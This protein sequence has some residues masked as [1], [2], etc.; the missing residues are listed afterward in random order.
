MKT[1]EIRFDVQEDIL[2]ALNQNI[3]EFTMQLRLYTA[4]QLFK[5]HKLSFGKAAELAG[6]AR[7][8]FLIELDKNEIDFIAYE[9]SE[10]EK[11]LDRF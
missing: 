11:E 10:L 6:V 5:K 1:A 2:N 8:E 9:P 7:D 3:A 4:L